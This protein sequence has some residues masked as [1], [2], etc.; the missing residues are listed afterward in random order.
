MACGQTVGTPAAESRERG[1]LGF[2]APP[3]RGVKAVC[4]LSDRLRGRRLAGLE[5]KKEAVSLGP[6]T[7]WAGLGR[8]RDVCGC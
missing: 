1:K 8:P 7:R 2:G 6:G 5:S 4:I 3:N